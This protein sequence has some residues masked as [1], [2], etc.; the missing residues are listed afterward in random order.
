MKKNFG[1]LILCTILLL[2]GGQQVLALET[3][4]GETEV[5]LDA[6]RENIRSKETNLGNL[7]ADTFIF[8]TGAQIAI[9]NGGGIRETVEP[10]PITLEDLLS[11]LPFEN[12][13]VTVEL[14]GEEVVAVLEHAVA[15]YP[16]LWGG[17]P[18]VSGISFTFDAE[19]PVGERV[20]E[21]LFGDEEP[22]PID[23]EAVYLVA[24][25]SFL[26]AGGD[27]FTML[28]KEPL[29]NFGTM[30]DVLIDYLQEHETVAPQVEGRITILNEAE[31]EA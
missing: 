27:G 1:I 6:A 4:M 24:T 23:Y 9:T 11:V 12:E 20:V 21:V 17:F 15:Q 30:L 14:T 19:K 13:V 2:L 16:A 5:F 31:P 7:I 28:E 18:Q 29:G 26:A 8:A 10:G 25:N 3:V 22:E